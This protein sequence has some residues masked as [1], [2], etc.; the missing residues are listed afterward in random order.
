MISIIAFIELKSLAVSSVQRSRNHRPT[1]VRNIHRTRTRTEPTKAFRYKGRGA[2]SFADKTEH[3]INGEVVNA[4]NSEYQ[5]KYLWRRSF[6][7]TK[8]YLLKNIHNK[9]L[10]TT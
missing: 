6:Q 5:G 9:L 1:Q 4:L 10:Y 8:H 2:V 7:Q 3:L